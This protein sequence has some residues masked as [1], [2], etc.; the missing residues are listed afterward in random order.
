[1]GILSKH[2]AGYSNLW[3]AG[4]ESTIVLVLEDAMDINSKPLTRI[5]TTIFA[6]LLLFGA[7]VSCRMVESLTGGEKAGT[8]NS[9]WPDVPPLVGATKADLAIPLGIRLML[10]AAMQGKINFIAF[11]TPKSAQEVKDFYSVDLMKSAG[12]TPNKQG[13]FGDTEDQKSEGAVCLFE[14]QDGG[15][16]EGLAIIVA[17]DKKTK[18]TDIF[19]ARI[20]LTEPSPSPTKR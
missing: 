18:Q 17:E 16:K 9:L 1:V 3:I 12:W 15:K 10:R 4:L 2:P 13:C 20:D 19:Y 11:T 7:V 14:R 5:S 8:V 6:L